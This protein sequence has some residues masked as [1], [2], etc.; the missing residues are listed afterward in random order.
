MLVLGAVH[1][2]IAAVPAVGFGTAFLFVIGLNM[3]TG[4]ARRIVGGK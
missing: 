4:Y 1:S 2:V 3:A